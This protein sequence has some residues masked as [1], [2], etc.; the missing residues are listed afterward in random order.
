MDFG[1]IIVKVGNLFL[2]EALANM[3]IVKIT[4][5]LLVLGFPSL[6][7]FHIPGAVPLEVIRLIQ[8]YQNGILVVHGRLKMHHAHDTCR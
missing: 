4:F 3:L 1:I 2:R 6:M 8:M 5:L 7:G